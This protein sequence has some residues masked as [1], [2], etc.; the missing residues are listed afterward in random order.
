MWTILT[1]A[2]A[3]WKPPATR[4]LVDARAL[5]NRHRVT[6][7]LDDALHAFYMADTLMRNTNAMS[8][9]TLRSNLKAAG[10][11]PLS[12]RDVSLAA[13]LKPAYLLRLSLAPSLSRLDATVLGNASAALVDRASGRVLADP[14]PDVY[15]GRLCVFFRG[16]D[17]ECNRGRFLIEKLAYLQGSLLQKVTLAPALAASAQMDGIS[18]SERRMERFSRRV[19]TGL[20]VWLRALV[21]KLVPTGGARIRRWLV[22]KLTNAPHSLL[23]KPLYR[24][25]G[26]V[27]SETRPGESDLSRFVL[28][29]EDDHLTSDGSTPTAAPSGDASVAAPRPFV[30]RVT[31]ADV[32]AGPSGRRLPR[33]LAAVRRLTGLIDALISPCELVEPTFAELI[34]VWRPQPSREQR[35]AARAAKGT[36]R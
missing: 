30:E 22:R 27:K 26:L 36:A 24:Y 3:A 2:W 6:S 14:I 33:P 28:L 31:I 10:Y 34:V 23:S 12:E 15:G 25:A 9:D 32:L 16:H 20:R 1:I 17:V 19:S 13:A 21:R 7:R 29:P 18:E 35:R 4:I 8:P 11:R 5:P